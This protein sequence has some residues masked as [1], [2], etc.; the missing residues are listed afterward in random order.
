MDP[1]PGHVLHRQGGS[2]IYGAYR[3]KCIVSGQE[4]VYDDLKNYMVPQFDVE[5]AE[6]ATATLDWIRQQPKEH[7]QDF[8]I[9]WEELMVQLMANGL[10]L[11]DKMQLATLKNRLLKKYD[12]DK[13][14]GGFETKEE[15][16]KY[17]MA[18][19]PRHKDKGN[20]EEEGRQD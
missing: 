12:L 14:K 17:C 9:R 6:D 8:R 13:V 11:N 5:A 18:Q 7:A 10:N 4:T 19:D 3:R 1:V 15:L 16:F 20:W 2:R